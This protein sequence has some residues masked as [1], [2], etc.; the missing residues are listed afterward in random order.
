MEEEAPGAA[1]GVTQG[2]H[3]EAAGGAS[4]GR[5]PP[6]LARHQCR[7]NAAVR[8]RAGAAG[9]RAAGGGRSGS[10]GAGNEELH[11]GIGPP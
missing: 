2:G 7:G 3:K 4:G 11:A 1:Q 5:P 9:E 10:F 8:S 6:P